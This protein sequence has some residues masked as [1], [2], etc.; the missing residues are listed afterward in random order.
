[1]YLRFAL[2]L[3]GV[4]LL[5]SGGLCTVV[6]AGAIPFEVRHVYPF[7]WAIE[8]PGYSF[9][10]GAGLIMIGLLSRASRGQFVNDC[11]N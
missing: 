2:Y 4:T 6:G 8:F 1:M 7:R 10:S 11:K 9:F 5:I 3:L